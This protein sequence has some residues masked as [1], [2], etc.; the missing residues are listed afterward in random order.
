MESDNEF[1]NQT[2]QEP[3]KN[4]MMEDLSAGVEFKVN[5]KGKP[6]HHTYFGRTFSRNTFRL[7]AIKEVKEQMQERAKNVK[8]SRVI[9]L[10]VIL[11]IIGVFSI[12]IILFYSL[13]ADPLPTLSSGFTDVNISM[14]NV[15]CKI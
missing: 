9:T 12:P 4:L 2:F 7:S 6:S 14:V 1:L 8:A 13:Q 10:I 15:Y 5:S 3:S 11:T